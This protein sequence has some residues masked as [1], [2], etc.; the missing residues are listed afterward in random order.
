M[1]DY[2]NVK[3]YEDIEKIFDS[4]RDELTGHDEAIEYGFNNDL[5]CEEEL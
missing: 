3:S 4:W 2:G 1:A 5:D